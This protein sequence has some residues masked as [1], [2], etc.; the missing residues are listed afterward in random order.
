MLLNIEN[1]KK[2]KI[3]SN[4]NDLYIEKYISKIK[5]RTKNV[6]EFLVTEGSNE[7]RLIFLLD[8]ECSVSIPLI[9]NNA[10]LQKDDSIKEVYKASSENYPIF[11]EVYIGEGK[12]RTANVI[13]LTRCKIGILE[14]N[15]FFNICENDNRIGYSVMKNLV[16]M[17]C[18]RFENSSNTVLKL[19]TAITVLL[20]R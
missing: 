13:A 2:Y 17:M 12:K 20:D 1:L 15:D 11:G 9:L 4:I 6:G 18:D 10:L 14:S 19:S 5:I 8:G 7:D 16:N 3:F